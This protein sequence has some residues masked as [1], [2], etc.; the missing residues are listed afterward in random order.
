[1]STER[2][3]AGTRLRGTPVPSASL[4]PEGDGEPRADDS[5]ADGTLGVHSPRNAT[6]RQPP[7]VNVRSSMPVQ[8]VSAR[9]SLLLLKVYVQAA[10]LSDVLSE[11]ASLSVP[12]VIA[13]LQLGVP[14]I[15]MLA[16][17]AA[18]V[19]PVVVSVPEHD[20]L[21]AV[22]VTTSV[23]SEFRSTVSV[24]VAVPTVSAVVHVPTIGLLLPLLPLHPTAIAADTTRPRLS[25]I[26]RHSSPKTSCL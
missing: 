16:A 15:V 26:D 24:N 8:A 2:A 19:Y 9:V 4:R 22:K 12:H 10:D 13:P 6:A 7:R 11:H 25:I 20:A 18:Q 5:P 14:E 17:V 1:M 3:G 23:P 21:A